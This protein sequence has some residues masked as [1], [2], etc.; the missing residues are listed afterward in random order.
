MGG[1][2]RESLSPEG[3]LDEL[4]DGAGWKEELKKIY[5]ECGDSKMRLQTIFA[6]LPVWRHLL[7]FEIVS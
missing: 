1:K 7:A 5:K 4:G 2:C 3:G 6:P